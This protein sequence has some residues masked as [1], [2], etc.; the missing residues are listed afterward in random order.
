MNRDEI[1]KELRSEF[2]IDGSKTLTEI[3][4]EDWGPP[5]PNESGVVTRGHKFR[6]VPIADFTDEQ[7]RFMLFQQIGLPT[8]VP[9]AIIWL[10]RDPIA[11][12]NMIEGTLLQGLLEVPPAFYQAHPDL[13]KK[14]EVL[15]PIA[16]AAA[17]RAA[18]HGECNLNNFEKSLSEGMKVF[19]TTKVGT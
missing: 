4:N 16:K 18:E 1:A 12:G 13:R 11:G 17:R 10:R 3:E 8:L 6:Y 7:L 19:S 2:G 14:V 5:P 9:A 15:I